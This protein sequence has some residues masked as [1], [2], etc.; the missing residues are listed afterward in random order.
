[1]II[2]GVKPTLV[3]NTMA[4]QKCLQFRTE[5]RIL[6]NIIMT[7]GQYFET[8]M[9][10]NFGKNN[11]TVDGHVF[12]SQLVWIQKKAAKAKLTIELLVFFFPKFK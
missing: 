10:S 1:L 6:M 3:Q 8:G 4:I 12:C 2:S 11:I 7:T 5:R 9:W